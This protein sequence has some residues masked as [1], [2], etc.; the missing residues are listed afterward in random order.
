MSCFHVS[1]RLRACSSRALDRLRALFHVGTWCSDPGTLEFRCCR[2]SDT[3]APRFVLLCECAV[4]SSLCRPL[5]CFVVLHAVHVF[6][7]CV[8]SCYVLCCVARIFCFSLAAC[9]H[10][11]MSCVNTWLMR[12]L[13]SC[14]FVSCFC[15]WLVIFCFAGHVLVFLFCVIIWLLS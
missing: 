15:T 9:F 6:I 10:V 3:R 11:V 12:I 14:M 13:I 7:G 2:G 1:V 8:H 4:S 5:L